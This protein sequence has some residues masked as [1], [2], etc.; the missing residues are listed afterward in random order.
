MSTHTDRSRKIGRTTISLTLA[1]VCFYLLISRAYAVS[2]PLQEKPPAQRALQELDKADLRGLLD[3]ATRPDQLLAVLPEFYDADGLH[4]RYVYPVKPGT[5]AN[6]L[7]M[8][9]LANWV[10]LVLYHRDARSAALLEVGFDGPPSRR[11]FTLLD[12]ANLEKDGEH[13]TVKNILNG[14]VSTWPEI[15][16]HIDQVSAMPLVNVPRA[17]VTRTRASCEFPK[18]G[19]KFVAVSANGDKSNWKFK[20]GASEGV[21]FT[22][23]FGPFENTDLKRVPYSRVYMN[24]YGPS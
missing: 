8:T 1:M 14:G 15:V 23:Q 10:T 6:M 12:G 7:N 11:T 13:W 4:I 9:G 17:Y 24:S 5:E 16:R 19:L 2:D 22:E 20:D 18:H 3:C 21:P